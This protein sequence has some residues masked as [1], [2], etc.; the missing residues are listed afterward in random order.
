MDDAQRVFDLMHQRDVVV[1]NALIGLHVQQKHG[2]YALQLYQE[3]QKEGM[4]P[5]QVTFLIV[6][7]ACIDLA[8]LPE[9]KTI[10]AFILDRGL[11]SNVI[12]GNALVNMYSKCGSLVDS[13]LVFS[14]M[15]MHD[16]VSWNAMIAAY[17]EHGND[18]EAL[19]VYQQ[20]PGA[21]MKP[22]EF[23][24]STILCACSSVSALTD[25]RKI[26][27]NIV[28]QRF[29]SDV[30][31]A[32]A[33][34]EMYNKCGCLED[35]RK[36]FDRIYQKTVYAWTAMIGACTQHGEG[37][38]ALQLFQH[39]QQNRVKPDEITF[40]NVLGACAS[41]SAL[42]EGKAIHLLARNQGYESD[43]VVGATLVNMYSKCGSLTD[44]QIVFD[45][46][47]YK[48]VVS[49][50]AMVA[51]YTQHGLV[52]KVLHLFSKMQADG[53]KPN[54]ITF[55]CILS[56]CSRAG[57]VDQ[58]CHYFDS[59]TDVYGII[60]TVE[61]YGC[62]IDLFGR[63]GRLKEAE[64]VIRKMP[65][66]PSALVW[67]TLLG[68]CQIYGD[69]E[70]GKRAA[71]H[72]IQLD[73]LKDSPYVLLSNIYAAEGRWDDV[74]KVRKTMSDL[75]VKKI[76]GFSSIEVRNSV[77]NF[78]VR[79]RSHPQ[80]EEIYN[81]LDRLS[82]QMKEAGYVPDTKLVLHDVEEEL[83]EHLLSYHSEKLAV[84]FGVLNTTP[85]SP[86]RIIK[87][88]R[89]CGDCHSAFKIISQVTGREI[90]LRDANRFHQFLNGLC[91]CADYW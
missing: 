58:G 88:L 53:V 21:A 10:H 14:R 13:Q 20:M 52:E 9:A 89:V 37:K 85:G 46:M 42:A 64:D 25:G 84:A 71:E 70:R 45:N 54:G 51:A 5:D 31:V 15:N 80:R 87:N 67:E 18:K 27:A 6:L 60:P 79:D 4:M 61:H 12:I 16:I 29:E 78:V 1:W 63:S 83:K 30:V 47:H 72:V 41:L 90:F 74:A 48:D 69:V 73:I 23:T 38:E 50:N 11:N 59:M 65:F 32:T 22:D 8:A 82:R 17:I 76:P 66:E 68:A 24:F 75:G 34:I 7:D 36:V 57:L 40:A 2:H 55:M 19:K 39:M 43:I 81:E 44:A 56:A 35:A 86:L 77:H 91:S 33:L 3:M 62:M 28:E 26:H 49:W